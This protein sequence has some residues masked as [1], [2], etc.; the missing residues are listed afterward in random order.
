MPL[1]CLQYQKGGGKSNLLACH[2]ATFARKMGCGARGGGY[3]R[4]GQRKRETAEQE[5][6][7]DLHNR[8]PNRHRQRDR[9]NST[10]RAWREDH[11]NMLN[12]LGL[13]T[14]SLEP[15]EGGDNTGAD[16]TVLRTSVLAGN[17]NVEVERP[18]QSVS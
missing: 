5:S 8:F 2:V 13:Q 14:L 15:D 11:G 12:G 6:I 16:S 3:G 1:G 17:T 4:E 9:A 18:P 7:L 10:P